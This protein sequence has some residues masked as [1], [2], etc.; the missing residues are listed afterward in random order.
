M[1]IAV[2][3][4]L[5]SYE[6]LPRST[7]KRIGIHKCSLPEVVQQVLNTSPD[8]F[9]TR[10]NLRSR[11]DEPIRPNIAE[12]RSE[13]VFDAS[14]VRPINR[15]ARRFIDGGTNGPCLETGA[16][17]LPEGI[18]EAGCEVREFVVV[19]RHRIACVTPCFRRATSLV[20][21]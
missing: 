4:L 21:V 16:V 10:T 6:Q 19:S 5:G 7:N 14:Q 20:Y 18:G 15:G 11:E 1:V 12:L 8:L 9:T 13:R 3:V 2:A 17:H